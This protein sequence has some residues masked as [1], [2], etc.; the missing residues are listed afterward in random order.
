MNRSYSVN[1]KKSPDNGV[2]H[3]RHVGGAD[4][5]QLGEVGIL[6]EEGR[7]V[8][9]GVVGSATHDQERRVVKTRLNV[10]Q[11][12]HDGWGDENVS[13]HIAVE[14]A[15]N[16]QGFQGLDEGTHI[17]HVV[18]IRL[19]RAGAQQCPVAGFADLL[20]VGLVREDHG[21]NLIAQTLQ[22]FDHVFLHSHRETVLRVNRNASY[23][24]S[25]CETSFPSK[26][27]SVLHPFGW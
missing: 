12:I 20:V 18:A 16:G 10:M 23:A 26:A 13:V 4:C 25:L 2:A 21:L 1:S 7:Y 3:V 11:N 6:G 14:G 22:S 5:V 24:R 19:K 8:L 9:P 17:R 27:F 15:R